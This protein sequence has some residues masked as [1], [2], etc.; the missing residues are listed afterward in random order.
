[1]KVASIGLA[2]ALLITFFG[3]SGAVG[4]TVNRPTQV[5][6]PT[7][8]AT[9]DPATNARRLNFCARR[10]DGPYCDPGG[11]VL[12]QCVG[13]QD[14]QQACPSGCNAEVQRCVGD[15]GVDGGPGRR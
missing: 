6:R 7:V 5:Q 2:T 8:G 10:A 11:A 13:G 1:M 3:V 14:S 9:L 4:Q 12:H 15:T